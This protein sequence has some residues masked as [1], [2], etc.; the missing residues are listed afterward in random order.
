MLSVVD[1][2]LREEKQKKYWKGIEL[3]VI[4]WTT[5]GRQQLQEKCESRLRKNHLN[6]Y[7]ST[8]QHDTPIKTVWSKMK[9]FKSSYTQQTYSLISNNVMITDPKEKANV[10]AEF[11]SCSSITGIRTLMI[12]GIVLKMLKSVLTLKNI[13]KKLNCLTSRML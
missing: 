7:V 9:S 4:Y 2:F 6:Q 12:L 5:T 3:K 13:I 1:W 8:L 11:F 10:L